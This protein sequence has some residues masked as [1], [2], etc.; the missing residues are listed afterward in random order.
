MRWTPA[1]PWRTTL[2]ISGS[3][4]LS[5]SIAS[6]AFFSCDGD[7]D[8]YALITYIIADHF[9]ARSLPDVLFIFGCRYYMTENVS[10]YLGMRGNFWLHFLENKLWSADLLSGICRYEYHFKP[11]RIMSRVDKRNKPETWNLDQA[12]SMTRPT[13]NVETWNMNV[14]ATPLQL[15]WQPE[16]SRLRGALQMLSFFHPR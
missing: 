5:A 12:Y 13:Q 3:Y 4:S 8:G 10:Q 6:S 2:A 15:R 7:V 14:P 1:L 16:W 11:Y 9:Q